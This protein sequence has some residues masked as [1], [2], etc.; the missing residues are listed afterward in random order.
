MLISENADKAARVGQWVSIAAP[1]IDQFLI[2]NYVVEYAFHKDEDGNVVRTKIDKA[3]R[4]F[5]KMFEMIETA[6]SNG[7]F[8]INSLSMVDCFVTPI[9]TATNM[10]PEGEEATLN[11]IPIRDYLSQMSERQNFK[12]TV[13]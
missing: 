6:V 10:W 8:G 7:Y 2:R 11:S 9:L 12:N 3:L 4:R 5:L 1:E 13:P